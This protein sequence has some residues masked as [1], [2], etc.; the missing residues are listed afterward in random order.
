VYLGIDLGT[1][2]VKALLV[3]EDGRIAAQGTAPLEASRPRPLWSEQDPEDWWRAAGAAVAALRR[4]ADLG[5]LRAIGLSG[6]MH[7]ATLLG[8]DLRPLRP[9]ILWND[10]RSAE[11]CRKLEALV[12]ASREITG[13]RA[14]PG[15]TA[16]KL[17]WVREHEPEVF[18]RTRAVLLPKDHL[19]LRLTGDLATDVSDASGTLW[20][21]VGRRAWSD[22]MLAACGLHAGAMPRLHEGTEATGRLRAEVAEA[23]GVPRV[24]V[25]AGGGDQAAGAAG[26]GVVRPSEASLSL[27]TSGVFFVAGD[28]FRPNPERAVHAFCHCLPGAWHQMSVMLSAASCVGWAARLLGAPDETALLAEAETRAPPSRRLLFLPYLSGE[29]TPH[30]DPDATGVFAGLTHDTDRADL[31]LAV[32]EGVAFAL[33]DGQDAI[34]ESGTEIGEV[35]VIGG[36]AR[37]ALWARILAS[38]L[39]RPLAYRASGD[40]G[41]A[42]GAARLA[43]I[44]ATGEPA[45]SVCT[46]PPLAHRVEPDPEL[47]GAY[48]ERRAAFR[49]LYSRLR[50]GFR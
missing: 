43:R 50:G 21:D 3:D 8:D 35:S 25:A 24:P 39:G 46:P 27:G 13:N 11:A 40:V 45:A 38:A 34:L 28:R 18:A 31:A 32:L 30:D 22:A 1:S 10:G 37:S 2:G 33:A 14:M 41:P 5:A 26:A 7:G 29:R 47:A 6:Q 16:P 36:G 19:R 23:W 44:A 17:L 48:V 49:E 12:P 15:F 4:S 42:L 20:L 9:A